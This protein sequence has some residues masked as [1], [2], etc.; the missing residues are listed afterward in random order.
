M[1]TISELVPKGWHAV[2]NGV[3][4]EETKVITNP[5]AQ[6]PSATNKSPTITVGTGNYI[7]T[8]QNDS[9][10][11]LQ[12]QLT[13]KAAPMPNGIHV[14]VTGHDPS[15]DAT[16]YTGDPNWINWSQ[17][18]AISDIPAGAKTAANP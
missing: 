17:V 1:S 16:D 9:D 13:V 5:A 18:G 7:V 11:T 6:D 2:G 15:Q 4:V 12:R 8:I 3:P 10:P 14:H